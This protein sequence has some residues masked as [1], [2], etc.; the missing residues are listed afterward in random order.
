MRRK[1][2]LRESML[3]KRDMLSPQERTRKSLMIKRRLFSTPEYKEARVIAF[4][5]SFRSEAETENM[6]RESL[7]LGKKVVLP[8][9]RVKKKELQMVYVKNFDKDLKPGTYGIIEPKTTKVKLD[10]LSQ[11]DIVVLPGSVFDL[12]GYRLGYGGGYYDRFLQ[13]LGSGTVIIGLAYEFQVVN[14]VP[15]ESHD[16]PVHQIVTENRIICCRQEFL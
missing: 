13:T 16:I 7:K 10:D 3:I 14:E 12:S 6:I 9:S 5:V 8:V 2:D 1:K 15:R 4:Y 11:L